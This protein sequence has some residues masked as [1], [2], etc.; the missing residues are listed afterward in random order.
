MKTGG[1]S[2]VVHL[3][4][5]FRPHEVYPDAGLDRRDPDDVAPYAAVGDLVA[6]SSSRRAEIRL[7]AGHF[8]F[9][10]RD[11]IGTDVRTLTLLRE[12]VERT[13]SVLKHFKRL[14]DRYR[15]LS[16]EAIYE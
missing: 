3:Q 9:A 8:P 16:L 10:A 2:L 12:P 4:K 14:R 5:E 13:I 6:L 7:Y 1:T 15:D 11:L